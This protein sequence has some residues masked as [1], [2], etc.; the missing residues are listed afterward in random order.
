MTDVVHGGTVVKFRIPEVLGV[1]EAGEVVHGEIAA[2]RS[3]AFAERV[4]DVPRIPAREPPSERCLQ[5]VVDHRLTAVDI[6][7][8][9]RTDCRV[10]PQTRLS[11]ERLS[12]LTLEREIVAVCPEV[13]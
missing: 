4:I 9:G 10:G 1:V 3:V 2:L 5:P 7:A 12:K 11:V 13:T 8:A 6:V